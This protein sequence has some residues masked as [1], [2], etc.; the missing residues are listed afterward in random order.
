MSVTVSFRCLKHGFVEFDVS[1]TA[2]W[3]VHFG[4][5]KHGFVDFWSVEI[6]VL[7]SEGTYFTC[8][9]VIFYMS[10][11]GDTAICYG[12]IESG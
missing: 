7:A 4:F 1:A 6:R 12:V 2:I 9:R 8:F 11:L 5:E 3:V 10:Q